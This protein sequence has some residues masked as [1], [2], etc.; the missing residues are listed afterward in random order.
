MTQLGVDVGEPVGVFVGVLVDVEVGELA[1]VAVAVG[2]FV[3]VAV[4][5]AV[6]VGE[7]ATVEVAVGVPP[8]QGTAAV[9]VFRGTGAVMTSK[10]LLLLFVSWQP[11]CL[12]TPP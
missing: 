7:L 4:A 9:A 10:S 12:R 1:M 6:D 11:F 3:R 2:V 8:T 5:V